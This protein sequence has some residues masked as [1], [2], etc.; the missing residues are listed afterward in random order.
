MI[1]L[2]RLINGA[3]K[4]SCV[5]GM[6]LKFRHEILGDQGWVSLGGVGYS[7]ISGSLGCAMGYLGTFRAKTTGFDLHSEV[8]LPFSTW[9]WG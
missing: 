6:E 4:G 1:D 5:S 2:D 3:R 7:C 9:H 8:M